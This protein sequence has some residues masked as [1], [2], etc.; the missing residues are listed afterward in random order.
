MATS[1]A[2]KGNK[3]GVK[4]KD[5]DV[6]QDA[7]N[8]FLDHIAKGNVKESWYYDQDGLT[9]VCDTMEQYIKDNPLEFPSTKVKAAYSKGYQHW[10]AVCN[11]SAAGAN[12]KANVASL[13]ML[14]RNKFK[15]DQPVKQDAPATQSDVKEVMDLIKKQPKVK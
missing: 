1:G 15:W 4:L 6:R 14:M 11:G 9:C 10:E 3:N 5:A 8:S 12:K 13:N 2:Q 7:F